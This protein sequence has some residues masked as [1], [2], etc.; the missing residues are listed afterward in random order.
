VIEIDGSRYSGSGTLVRQAVVFSALTGQAVRIFNARARRT[1]PGLR[2]QHVRVVEAIRDLVG[3][4]VEGVIPGSREILFRPGA[5]AGGEQ[6]RWDMGSAGSTINLGLS[7]LPVLAFRGVPTHVE[8]RGGLFQDFA[9]SF[10]HLR[11]VFVPLLARMGLHAEVTMRRPGYVPRGEGVVELSVAPVRTTLQSTI[12]DHGGVPNHLWGIAMSSH[13]E[14]RKVSQRMADAAQDV[15]ASAGHNASIEIINDTSA[16]QAGAS[17]ALFADLQGSARL[18]ADGAGAPGR[19]AEAIGRHV[20]RQLLED[21]HT[22]AALDR[23]AADQVIPFAA[24]AAGESR[25]RI[26][27][28]T[29]HI[30]SNAW[31]AQLFLGVQTK[32]QGHVMTIRGLGFQRPF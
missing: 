20:A 17:L 18:G 15:L 32:I 21:L 1:K 11:H 26:P 30:T 2:T 27:E 25:F 5:L 28:E 31:L 7:I 24:L 22:S 8:L 16:A 10:Y 13:L 12:M 29:E 4:R 6:Y 19:P 3:A 9:P 14:Q 23:H